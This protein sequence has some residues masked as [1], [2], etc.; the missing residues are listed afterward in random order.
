MSEVRRQREDL[1]V[2]V[3][4]RGAPANEG[5]HRDR[6]TQ[7]VQAWKRRG[8]PPKLTTEPPEGGRDLSDPLIFLVKSMGGGNLPT[9]SGVEAR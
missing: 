9:V 6:V 7:I 1:L 3:L 8:G 5:L 4:A 2:H